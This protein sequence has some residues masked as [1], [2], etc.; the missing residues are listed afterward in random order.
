SAFLG[1]EAV[2]QAYHLWPEHVGRIVETSAGIDQ[3]VDEKRRGSWTPVNGGLARLAVL[4]LDLWRH[5][6]LDH[7]R[8]TFVLLRE[9]AA[10]LLLRHDNPPGLLFL[11][12]LRRLLGWRCGGWPLRGSWTRAFGGGNP[13]A[14]RRER[15]NRS[16]TKHVL[17][18]SSSSRAVERLD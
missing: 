10:H 5:G 9:R 16:A 4:E 2:D 14:E 17:H 8:L 7:V 11:R 3:R 18:R 6:D 15:R 12:Q 1:G 13:N